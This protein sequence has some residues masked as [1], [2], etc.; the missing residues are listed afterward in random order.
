MAL[1]APQSP[2]DADASWPP[3][4]QYLAVRRAVED[5]WQRCELGLGLRFVLASEWSEETLKYPAGSMV[6]AWIR[7][8][9]GLRQ[10][11]VQEAERVQPE[12]KE[13]GGRLGYVSLAFH[14]CADGRHVAYGAT[15]GGLTY[16]GGGRCWIDPADPRLHPTDGLV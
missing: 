11:T 2:N 16:F 7:D 10:V 6:R 14:V 9:R 3:G 8:G 5:A 1:D 12:S 13:P 15:A 4:R